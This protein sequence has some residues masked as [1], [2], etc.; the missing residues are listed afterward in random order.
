MVWNLG[1]ITSVWREPAAM[2]WG[3]SGNPV[4]KIAG[5]ATAVDK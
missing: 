1:I 2:P 4:K 5:Q 3:H